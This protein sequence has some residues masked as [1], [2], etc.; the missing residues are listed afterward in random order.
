MYCV[1][2]IINKYIMSTSL[3]KD[4][5]KLINYLQTKGYSQE[6]AQGFAEAVQDFDTADLATKAD[7][8]DLRNHDYKLAL[9]QIA[10]QT[11]LLFAIL[12]IVL[13]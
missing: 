10:V 12:E 13:R 7:L 2:I 1:I 8:K 11:G 6:Q 5:H 3:I 4:T 9:G